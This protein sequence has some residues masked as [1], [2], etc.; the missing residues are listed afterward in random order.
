MSDHN[1]GRIGLVIGDAGHGKSMC[2]RQYAASDQNSLYV[3]LD[4]TMTITA[5]FA[6]IAKAL[7]IDYSGGKRKVA[8]RLVSALEPRSLVVMLDEASSLVVSH[9]DQL[10]Q[11][12]AV[13]SK[14]PLIL[15]GNSHLL[16]TINQ[17][18]TKR[19]YESLD[20]FYSRLVYVANLDETAENS[21]GGGGG[22]YTESDIKKL[23][24][25]GG[26]R[27][28]KSGVKTIQKLCRTAM[29]GRL[30]TCS[31]VIAALH[32]STNEDVKRNVDA[33]II[34]AVIRQL[35]LPIMNRLPMTAMEMV[36]EAES[37]EAVA[38]AG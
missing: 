6:A 30:R 1:E 34:M 31:Q 2:L 4:S 26:I 8:D 35:G 25:H 12:I 36:K 32:T 21:K 7:G 27:L 3:E 10:R 17:P 28:V 16:G 15:A 24:Q 19:G 22:L 37:Q 14:C 33:T 9:L 13:K 18:P 11:I 23:Y 29:S 5:I 38:A 20:Q